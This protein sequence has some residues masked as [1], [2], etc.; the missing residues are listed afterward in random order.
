[1]KNGLILAA[2]V[3]LF[4]AAF[5]MD[6]ATSVT[7]TSQSQWVGGGAPDNVTIQGGNVSDANVDQ[8]TSTE[9]WGGFFGNVSGALVLAQAGDTN[10]LFDWAWTS[11]NATVCVS[12][13]STFTWSTA[14][15]ALYSD[16]S[17]WWANLADG[18]TDAAN[19]TFGVVTDQAVWIGNAS[20][21]GDTA[22][23]NGDYATVVLSSDGSATQKSELAFCVEA[24]TG[25]IYKGDA[26]NYEM[27]VPTEYDALETYFFYVQ[28]N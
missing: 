19:N 1:M 8:N 13:G 11:G 16:I 14:A 18:P 15:G 22:D 20:V 9:N 6:N 17:A 3:L 24:G 25:N 23:T 12:T 21:A 4:G 27:I 5:A 2:F 26:G 28:L 10:S 7:A